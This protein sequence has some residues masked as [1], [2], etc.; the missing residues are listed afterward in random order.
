MCLNILKFYPIRAFKQLGPGRQSSPGECVLQ[1]T[2]CDDHDNKRLGWSSLFSYSIFTSPHSM[3]LN[4]NIWL[5]GFTFLQN[6]KFLT[7]PLSC[8]FQR[9]LTPPQKQTK[10]RNM[11]R[12][13]RRSQVR[14]LIHYWMWAPVSLLQIVTI[15]IMVTWVLGLILWKI[16]SPSF[17]VNAGQAYPP[18]FY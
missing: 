6:C 14:I 13:T 11:T 7:T 5:Q 18:R 12:K 2:S 17:T 9:D 4:S 10:Y 16:S 15:I 8:N 1:Y 3:Y